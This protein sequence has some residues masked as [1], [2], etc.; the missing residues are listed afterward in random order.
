MA[1]KGSVSQVIGPVVDVSF[2][3]EGAV[4]PEIHNALVV[5]R[6]GLNESTLLMS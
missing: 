4:L 1:N 2:T 6:E 5:K 3:S